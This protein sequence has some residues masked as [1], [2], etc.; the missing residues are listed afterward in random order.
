MS[1]RIL[2]TTFLGLALVGSLAALAD[3]G[4]RTPLRPFAACMDP[5]QVRGWSRIGEDQ[6]LVDAGHRRYHVMLERQCADLDFAT[7]LHF[8]GVLADAGGRVCGDPGDRLVPLT[9]TG[10]ATPCPIVRIVPVNKSEYRSLLEGRTA[11]DRAPVGAAADMIGKP[12]G[13]P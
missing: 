7:G 12:G 8:E 6:L 1:A 10:K 3:E 11:S 2:L 5:S 4:E 9:T 13:Q